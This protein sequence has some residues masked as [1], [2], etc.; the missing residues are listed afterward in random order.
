LPARKSSW[1]RC[2]LRAFFQ[3]VRARGGAQLAAAATSRKLAV[4]F[5]HLLTHEQD[6]AFG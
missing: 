6:Y 2:S 4:L 1:P 5:W 3:H